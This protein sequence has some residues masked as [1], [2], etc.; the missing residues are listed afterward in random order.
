MVALAEFLNRL[1]CPV[2]LKKVL[3]RIVFNLSYIFYQKLIHHEKAHFKID[4]LADICIR[5][6]KLY[7]RIPSSSSLAWL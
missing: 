6:F 1:V 3:A 4:R 5:D 2:Y 7:C